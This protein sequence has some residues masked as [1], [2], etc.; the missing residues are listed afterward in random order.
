MGA[1]SDGDSRGF[2][3]YYREYAHSAIH[4][5]SAAALTALIGFASFA[6]NRWFILLAIIVYVFPPVF[7][8]LTG[9]GERVPSVVGGDTGTGDERESRNRATAES[10]RREDTDST[11]RETG[12]DAGVESTDTADATTSGSESSPH[13]ETDDPE[14]VVAEIGDERASDTEPGWTETDTSTDESLL[15]VVA[16]GSGAYAVGEGG[17]V[18]TRSDDGWEAALEHGPTANSNP[19]L[20]VDA[21]AD[22]GAVWFTGDSGVLGRYDGEQFTDYSAPKDQTSTWEDVAVTGETGEEQIHLVNGSGELLWGEYNG[23]SVSWGDIEKPGG[24][25]SISSITFADSDCGYVCDTNQG[26]Y[27][28]TDGGENYENIG[29]EDA[30]TDFNGVAATNSTVVVA[31]GDGSVF[32]Y[33]GSVWTRLH[34]GSELA[35]I[36]LTEEEGLAAGGGGVVYELTDGSWE[37]VE[38]PVDADLHGVAISTGDSE[39]ASRTVAVGTDGTVIERW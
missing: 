19:L 9:E 6:H 12:P 33:D 34:A 7:L 5:V 21:T 28:T 30:N 13:A 25:S 36:D 16:T 8:Y 31:G 38:T 10:D 23:S 3:A 27:E 2:F 4:A 17:V 15:D 32:R 39:Q 1:S 35:T 24:G 29:I 20:G 14:S 11:T 37:S 18:L 26:V 22:G